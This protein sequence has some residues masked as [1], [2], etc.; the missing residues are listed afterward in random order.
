HLL[1]IQPPQVKPNRLR[2]PGARRSL[3]GRPARNSRPPIDPIQQERRRMHVSSGRF[4]HHCLQD[5]PPPSHRKRRVE[6]H[7]PRLDPAIILSPAPLANLHNP[8]SH[9]TLPP[10]ALHALV[11]QPRNP[12][13]VGAGYPLGAPPRP[14]H[15]C[16]H[17]PNHSP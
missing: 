4:V 6:H 10:S 1:F 17:R 3:R 16:P 12:C 11:H 15:W 8:T 5:R 7:R 9:I 13:R 14:P 2:A